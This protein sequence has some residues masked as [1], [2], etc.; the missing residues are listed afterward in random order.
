MY[1]HLSKN[2]NSME[3]IGNFNALI[4]LF[5][6]LYIKKNYLYRFQYVLGAATSMAI[7]LTEETLTYLNQGQSY[8]LKLKKLGDLSAYRG[9]ILKVKF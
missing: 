7:K 3:I 5:I 2:T 1:R 4:I 8:E 9:R 6:Y